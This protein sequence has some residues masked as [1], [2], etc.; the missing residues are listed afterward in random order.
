MMRGFPT[1]ILIYIVLSMLTMFNNYT[2]C[3]LFKR[4]GK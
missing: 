1:P 2:Y 3:Y 4:R